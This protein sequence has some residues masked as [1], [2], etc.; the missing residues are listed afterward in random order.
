MAPRKRKAEEQ[1]VKVVEAGEPPKKYAITPRVTRSAARRAAEAE[2]VPEKKPKAEPQRKKN[3]GKGKQKVVAE[4]EEEESTDSESGNEERAKAKGARRNKAKAKAK[5]KQKV[6]AEEEEE[7]KNSDSENGNGDKAKAAQRKN[8]NKGKGKQKVVAEDDEEAGA[9]SENEKA[10]D[11]TIVIEHCTQ[12]TSFKKRA[13]QVKRGLED[14]VSGISV[15]VNPNKPRRGCFEIRD[16]G[17][18]GEKFI[19][20][21]FSA[22]T[23]LFVLDSSGLL[24]LFAGINVYSYFIWFY[25]IHVDYVAGRILDLFSFLE[26]VVTSVVVNS[27]VDFVLQ[28]MKRPFKPMKDLDMAQVIED[29]IEKIK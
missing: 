1:G 28:E 3:R 27:F 15:L 4:E 21:L 17:G 6:V 23:N 22:C 18:D 9:D 14:G 26:T 16:E 29:I 13:E 25:W 8:K 11:K 2:A 19:S 10:S 24:D 20:L 12:C 5:G 7:E